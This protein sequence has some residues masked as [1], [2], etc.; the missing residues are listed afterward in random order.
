M[1][2]LG[3]I[4]IRLNHWVG[5]NLEHVKA[6]EEVALKLAELGMIEASNHVRQAIEFSS[7]ANTNFELALKL[8]ESNAGE[9]IDYSQAEKSHHHGFSEG[10]HTHGK[11]DK[12]HRH[13]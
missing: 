2:E 12:V 8:V 3:K 11:D 13:S 1:D 9:N 4:A 6:Y 7:K 10:T 5:H